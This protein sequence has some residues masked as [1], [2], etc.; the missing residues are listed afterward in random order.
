MCLGK[1]R[2]GDGEQAPGA[3]TAA[4]PGGLV[5]TAGLPAPGVG[6]HQLLL[7][8]L[9]GG[10]TTTCPT[11]LWENREASASSCGN[12]RPGAVKGMMW[13]GPSGGAEAHGR[14]KA[15]Q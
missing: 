5:D 14:S 7:P 11:G 2:P 13:A 12:T 4:P 6:S 1:P 9:G 3:G 15:K 10:A 8:P